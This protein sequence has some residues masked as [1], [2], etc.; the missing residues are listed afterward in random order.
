MRSL[1][2]LLIYFSV[3]VS[4]CKK[5]NPPGC[6]IPAIVPFQPYSDPVWH[7]NGQLIGFNHTPLVGIAPTG[8]A[9]CIWYFYFGRS[10]STGFYL[11]NRNGTGFKRVTNF[12]LSAPSWS[13]DGN[14]IA[15]SLGSNIYKMPFNGSTFDTTQII[16][17]TTSGGNFYPSWTGNSDTIFFDSNVGTN[18]GGYYVWKMASDGSGKTGFPNTGREP[19]VGSDA[20]VYYL[21]LGGEIYQMNIDGSN[22][23]KYSNNGFASLRP[24]YWQ[25][26]VF[27]E[28]NQIG[29]V[30]T[31]GSVGIQLV[32]PAV[33]YD[34]SSLGEVV[35]SK[36]EYD[37]TKYIKQIGTLWIMNADGSNKRQLT[38]N[39]F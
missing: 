7:P 23:I 9:P 12:T 1:F 11:M 37:I 20:K 38:F 14:W 28:G 2:V 30:Q 29:V 32:T 36:M 33:T 35:Y 10:D 26:K 17:L 21:G 24:R 13:P 34:V 6:T 25:G 18:G 39:N 27:Y 19:F 31:M 4:C 8:T 22:Q 16:Q 3:I 5:N 15:F